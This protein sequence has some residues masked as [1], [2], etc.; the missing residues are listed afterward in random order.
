MD[1]EDGVQDLIFFGGWKNNNCTDAN[2]V[3]Y[4]ALTFV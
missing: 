4:K 2:E 1:R 3:L